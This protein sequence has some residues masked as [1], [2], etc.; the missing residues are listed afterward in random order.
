M[1][2]PPGPIANLE[3]RWHILVGIDVRSADFDYL[4]ASVVR[5]SERR[6]RELVARVRDRVRFTRD[7]PAVSPVVAKLMVALLPLSAE[8]IR[9]QLNT[10]R[11][12]GDYQL[13]FSLFCF[14][15][16]APD[17][18]GGEGFAGQVPS[19]VSNYL[20]KVP[21]DTAQAAWMAGDL[22]GEHWRSQ[23]ALPV[24]L[25]CARDAR[26][27]PGRAGAVHGLAHAR[28]RLPAE[29][30]DQVLTTLTNVSRTDRSQ[31]V[32]RYAKSILQGRDPCGR[33]DMN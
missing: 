4:R 5:L 17:L 9:R 14:L 7:N 1:V 19:L 13:H 18:P 33:F 15:E 12:A 30:A 25:R 6:K 8:D 20:M 27:A 29:D 31:H 16:H 28:S 3:S 26:F 22:L 24:L 23:V 2:R 11:T 10:F 32:R 21:R